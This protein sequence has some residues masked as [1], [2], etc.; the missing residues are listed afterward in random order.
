MNKPNANQYVLDQPC[1]LRSTHKFRKSLRLLYDICLQ[2]VDHTCFIITTKPQ[3]A[4][5]ANPTKDM[6][7]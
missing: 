6:D 2:V 1:L 3:T 7:F 5:D 4:C